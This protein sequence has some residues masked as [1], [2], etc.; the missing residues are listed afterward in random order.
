M[1]KTYDCDIIN[2]LLPSYLEHLTSAET[3]V[4]ISEHLKECDICREMF[5]QM[6]C[7]LSFKTGEQVTMPS[8]AGMSAATDKIYRSTKNKHILRKLV[9]GYL[10]FLGI[11]DFFIITC[12]ILY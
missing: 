2:D 5:E 10:I 9:L 8:Q 1:S 6:N 3:N 4:L 12:M 11:I 7:D